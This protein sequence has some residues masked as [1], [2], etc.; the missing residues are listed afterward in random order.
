MPVGSLPFTL[1]VSDLL[2][3]YTYV[4]GT[5]DNSFVNY[6]KV[7]PFLTSAHI[8]SSNANSGYAKAGD[9]ITLT[10]TSNVPLTGIVMTL[11]NT[12]VT[13]LSG[14]ATVTLFSG[15]SDGPIPFAMVF[16]S[17]SGI[18]VTG[19]VTTTSDG[20][21][22]L[23]DNTPPVIH[24]ITGVTSP[25]LNRTPSY[26][27]SGNETGTITSV[28]GTPYT[29]TAAINGTTTVRSGN[30][31]ILFNLLPAGS[32]SIVITVKDLAGNLQIF[33]LTTFVITSP[34]NTG[35]IG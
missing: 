13:P 22:I 24:E 34:V 11:A 9:V 26:T 20:S 18:A 10:F 25:T 6:T 7:V 29:G 33:P 28:S 17:M 12:A 3:N 35:N 16:Q 32:Y 21:S 15:R 27:F 19:T 4:T 1:A 2:G 30:N 8:A 23:Y 5:T 31:T 14:V